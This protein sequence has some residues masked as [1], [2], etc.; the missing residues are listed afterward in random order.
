MH[1]RDIFRKIKCAKSST[2]DI[3]QNLQWGIVHHDIRT[4]SKE[5]VSKAYHKRSC[6]F[7]ATYYDK[8]SKPQHHKQLVHSSK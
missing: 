2:T 1:W 4:H 8:E 3:N 5:Q 6:C 7:C